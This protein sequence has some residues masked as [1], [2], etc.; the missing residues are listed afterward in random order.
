MDT[1]KKISLYVFDV[2][3]NNEIFNESSKLN[4]DNR[5]QF[6]ND[7]KKQ[8]LNYNIDISTQDINLPDQSDLIL[9][10][11]I[12]RFY[13]KITNKKVKEAAIIF[14]CRA[15]LPRNWNKDRHKRLDFAFTWDR[16]LI[17]EKKYFALFFSHMGG[18]QFKDF[19]EKKLCTMISGNK[20]SSDQNELYS[21]R[22][23]T[24]RWFEKNHPED[25]EFYGTG[26]DMHTFSLPIPL[27]NRVLNRFSF[28]RKSFSKK[29]PSYRGKTN[30]KYD[31]L[32][33]YKF[34]ICYENAFGF[35]GYITEK[36]FESMASGCI[37]IYWGDSNIRTYVPE[38][39]FVDRTAFQT[40]EDLYHFI[41]SI[42]EDEYEGRL[43][44]I[45]KYLISKEHRYF[46]PEYNAAYVA[47][48]ISKK[49]NA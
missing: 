39:C 13:P 29:W 21:E 33:N 40:H 47:E 6:F 48:I 27:I 2:F 18:S 30:N 34:S 32:S 8:L 37:P 1:K 45:K 4:I 25:F 10:N 17:D 23:K 15:I 24:I 5:L 7:L 49:I 14:E 26:W 31:T 35:P 41:T 11:D 19:N 36:I 16:N 28:L 42:G 38:S 46:E 43:N 44:S 20:A 3:K 12:P 22:I 9:Y